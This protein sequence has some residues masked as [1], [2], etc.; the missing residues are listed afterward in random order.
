VIGL[1]IEITKI[2]KILCPDTQK[3]K[4]FPVGSTASHGNWTRLG[5]SLKDFGIRFSSPFISTMCSE[6]VPSVD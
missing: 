6:I 1:V 3:K 2:K 5:V 4:S